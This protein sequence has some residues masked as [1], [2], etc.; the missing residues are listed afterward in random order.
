MTDKK[1]LL[2]AP[3]DYYFKL[4][5]SNTLDR[6]PTDSSSV[7]DIL[8]KLKEIAT[9][10]LIIP[11]EQTIIDSVDVN[12]SGLE[13]IKH[14]R[15]TPELGEVSKLPL[16]CLHWHSVDYYVNIDR[17][18]IF[19]Y[20]PGI[21]RYQYPFENIDIG[22]L[23]HLEES[24]NPF[25]FG[26]EKDEYI[27]DH[28]FRNEIAIKQ[29][30]QQVNNPDVELIE[31]E[32]WFKKIFYKNFGNREWKKQ[33]TV[34]PILAPIKVLFADDMA[35]KWEPALKKMMPSAVI[36]TVAN[37]SEVN[38]ILSKI[39]SNNDLAIDSFNIDIREYQDA[40]SQYKNIVIELS[41]LKEKKVKLNT[42]SKSVQEKI[43]SIDNEKIKKESEFKNL[44]NRLT[45]NGGLIDA[46]IGEVNSF[47]LTDQN[48]KD[49][50]ELSETIRLAI[51]QRNDMLSLQSQ[52]EKLCTEIIKTEDDLKNLDSAK[53]SLHIKRRTVFSK[54]EATLNK[55]FTSE[56]DLIL[57][58][59]YFS[60][61][62]NSKEI[63]NTAGFD[64]LR[65][66]SNY[67]V[68]IPIVIFSASLQPI[69][70]EL[71]SL[72][73]KYFRFIK[74]VTPVQDLNEF[75]ITCYNNIEVIEQIEIIEQ[76]RN[77]SN[78][79]TRKYFEN[80][81]AEYEDLFMVAQKEQDTKQKLQSISNKLQEYISKKST[82]EK[83]Q[84]LIEISQNLGTIQEN[85]LIEPNRNNGTSFYHVSNLIKNKIGDDEVFLRQV[86]NKASHSQTDEWKNKVNFKLIKDLIT[87]T[88]KKLILG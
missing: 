4:N 45:N 25:L 74:G 53:G 68:H 69:E 30:E 64:I 17:E 62:K 67:K 87:T 21:Y 65:Q 16:I 32:I 56:F 5:E 63:K 51:S 14:I 28:V 59:L 34:K 8:V 13:L 2:I 71:S 1:Y 23:K 85:R 18:N 3:A 57:V 66:L 42:N 83:N 49:A 60:E 73:L 26:S 9:D 40:L 37:S 86:R 27:S 80:D 79:F 75:I 44:I 46:L 22:E 10:V 29:F 15:L 19:L 39:K 43:K 48:K 41:E 78:Y 76:I 58:D 11:I 35:V 72:N 50:N 7:S 61:T 47:G 12:F 55:L 24:L 20:S 36:K 77:F 54:I 52:W 6:L 81:S 88:Y 33:E 38:T 82:S 84:L 31:K 70:H